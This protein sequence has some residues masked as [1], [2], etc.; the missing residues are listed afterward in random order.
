[1]RRF[2][3]FLLDEGGSIIIE[4][5]SLDDEDKPIKASLCEKHVPIR[6]E[7]SFESALEKIK[8]LSSELISKIESLANKPDEIQLEFA[9]I[10]KAKCGA[11]ITSIASDANF[12]I[13]LKWNRCNQ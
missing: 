3:E 7:M 8:P 5:E 2:T 4:T 1:M 6:A 11:V 13:T 12:K 9:I 10:L